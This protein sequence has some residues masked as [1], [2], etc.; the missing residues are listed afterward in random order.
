MAKGLGHVTLFLDVKSAFPSIDTNQLIHNMRKRGIPKE[1]TAWMRRRL[2][3]RKTILSFDDHQTDYFTVTNSLPNQ[4]WIRAT[5]S[6]AY[7]TY[8]YTTLTY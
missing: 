8:Y 2:C 5:P 4:V 3:D 1:Y 7:A 6:P